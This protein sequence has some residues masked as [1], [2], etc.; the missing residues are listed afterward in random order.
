MVHRLRVR[1]FWL[2]TTL[3]TAVVGIPA[4]AAPVNTSFNPAIHGFRF[5]NTFVNDPTGNPTFDIR[6]KGLCGGMS[7][8]AADFYFANRAIPSQDYRPAVGT[9]LQDYLY[10]RQ[11]KAMGDHIDKWAE[12][13]FNPFGARDWEFFSWGLG[14]RLKELRQKIDAGLPVPLGLQSYGGGLDGLGNNHYVLAIG[15]DLGRYKGDGGAYQEDLRIFVYDPNKHGGAR[16]LAPSIA[17][18]GYYFVDDPTSI[19][20]TY[21]VDTKYQPTAPPALP[22]PPPIVNDGLVRE[23]RLAIWTGDDDLR[24][25]SDCANVTLH[26]PTSSL[27]F[28]NVNAGH[29]WIKNYDQTL[30]FTLPNP[31]SPAEITG[32]TVTTTFGG[33]VAGDNWNVNKLELF[34]VLNGR[35]VSLLKREGIPLF[36]FTGS[37]QRYSACVNALTLG[38]YGG[39]GFAALPAAGTGRPYSAALIQ[40]GCQSKI[41]GVTGFP[42]NLGLTIDDFGRITGTPPV[43][44]KG[45][46]KFVFLVTD[47]SS[48]NPVTKNGTASLKVIDVISPVIQNLSITPTSL[49]AEG[50][51]MTLLVR[52][53]DN[54]GVK[55]GKGVYATMARP[56]GTETGFDLPLVSGTR[57]NGEW[58][59]TWMINANTGSTAQ[60]F[61]IKVRVRDETDN[62]VES[63]LIPIT[64]AGRTMVPVNPPPKVLS[65]TNTP[66]TFA[67]SGGN[68]TVSVK[69]SD[70]TGVGEVRLIVVNPDGTQSAVPR[71]PLVG[72]TAMNGEW[73]Y[74]WVMPGNS[75]SSPKV[76]GIQASVYDTGG[77][78]TTS[79]TISVT[80]PV[81][82]A[83]TTLLPS[84]TSLP[85]LP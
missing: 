19:W 44:F 7:Y 75:T 1:L 16:V 32:V 36:R 50:G 65:F 33:G 51:Q 47:D 3:I 66:T 48:A 37:A 17:R 21:F 25:A 24:G 41:A 67:Y 20:R 84:P 49:P 64:V 58:R 35:A 12:L 71:I 69:A 6:T 9:L 62:L 27:T 43:N 57:A 56:D 30:S 39:S 8:A 5:I 31:V 70:D 68:I 72:G 14:G 34:S 46:F 26:F 18:K 81:K 80:V 85:K 78:K 42:S 28:P 13:N 60:T 59:W 61:G 54:I 22:A 73:R 2:A 83:G 4:E 53:T 10:A 40:G 29:H 15:Y 38:P 74:S 63:A 82:P 79:Q 23:V 76:Y 77:A 11:L 45:E 52:A 55:E